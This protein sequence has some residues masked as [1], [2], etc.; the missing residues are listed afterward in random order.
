MFFNLLMNPPITADVSEKNFEI[1]DIKYGAHCTYGKK[2]KMGCNICYCGYQNNLLC[3]KLICLQEM[4]PATTESEENVRSK[5]NKGSVKKDKKR[6]KALK[7]VKREN[8]PLKTDKKDYP[9]LPPS[10][11]CFPGRIYQEGCQLCF[12][13]SNR[14]PVCSTED[15]CKEPKGKT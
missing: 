10:K 15:A 5:I 3:T 14:K 8:I 9:T 4:N 11:V 2:Y 7:A 12:C 1:P 6:K 13:K